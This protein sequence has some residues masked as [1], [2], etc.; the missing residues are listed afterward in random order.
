MSKNTYKL[1]PWLLMIGVI[2][3]C[4][5]DSESASPDNASNI[6]AADSS[7]VENSAN[8]IAEETNDDSMVAN[9]GESEF[10]FSDSGETEDSVSQNISED[11]N[12]SS[13][14][15]STESELTNPQSD[16]EQATTNSQQQQTDPETNDSANA[17]TEE[18]L[19][20][21]DQQ[22][23]FNNAR[24]LVDL[25]P[26]G[27]SYPDKFYRSGDQLY[28]WTIDT[29]PL[30]ANCSTHWG[31]L[32]DADKT[33]Q[34]S[35]AAIH[36]ETGVVSMNRNI[37]TVG[38]FAEDPNDA[39][40]GYNGSIMQVYEQTW[41]TAPATGEQQFIVHFN[42]DALGPNLLWTTDGSDAN[43]SL[44]ETGQIDEQLMFKGDKVFIVNTDGLWVSD[45]LTGERRHLFVSPN[46]EYHP[47]INQIENSPARQATFEIEVGANRFQIW[48]YDLDTDEWV[49]K[50]SIKPDSDVYEHFETLSVEGDTLLTHGYN[51]IE[52]QLALG[53][54]NNSGDVTSIEI[55]TE[56]DLTFN[57][58]ETNNA[59][60]LAYSSRDNSVVPPVIS[61]WNYSEGQV[62]NLFS[63]SEIGLQQLSMIAGQDGNTYLAGT[64]LQVE[65]SAVNERLELWSYN[66]Q[67]E[68]LVKLSEDDWYAQLVSQPVPDDG[69][70]FRYQNTPDG[71][72]FVNL[73]EDS[74]REV[75]FTNGSPEGT[76]QLADINPGAGSSDPQNFYYTGNAIYF[77]ADDGTHGHEPWVIEITR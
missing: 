29:D 25:T 18:Q 1:G 66:P 52:R 13:N 10:D 23:S 14:E 33:V 2:S 3:G 35:L 48:M 16:G 42:N 11:T 56:S 19:V 55:L 7:T 43:T 72:I 74:G 31:N 69:Y 34:L 58:S 45:T 59:E 75:W 54:S 67:T 36:P 4:G 6:V 47:Q 12:N 73:K 20:V 39:C 63:V 21:N 37:M 50:F 15:G 71:L 24:L 26:N 30:F 57:R 64:T 5:S 8:D 46:P 44:L 61:V 51:A 70:I 17:Q 77:S 9:P 40:A 32:N 62:E 65:S 68:Q 28:F 53:Q 41:I 38:D 49:K 27:D 22:V 76:R 60:R